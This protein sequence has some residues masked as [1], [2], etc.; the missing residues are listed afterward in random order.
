VVASGTRVAGSAWK[1]NDSTFLLTS[2]APNFSVRTLAI[3]ST[4]AGT[5]SPQPV[6]SE[7]VTAVPRVAPSVVSRPS[8]PVQPVKAH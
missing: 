6:V 4:R 7:A 8:G 5:P 2:R 1:K 3:T